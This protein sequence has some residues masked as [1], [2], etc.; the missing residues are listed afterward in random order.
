MDIKEILW[1]GMDLIYLAQDRYQRRGLVNMADERTIL[2]NK[3][4]VI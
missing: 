1:E 3:M 2:F 4:P